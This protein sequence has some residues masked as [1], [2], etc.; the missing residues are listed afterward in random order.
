MSTK[1]IIQ[2][3]VSQVVDM[4]TGE[5][6]EASSTNI[7]RL[8]SEPPYV[9]MYLDDLCVLINVPESQKNLLLHLLRRL[10]FEGYIILSPRARKD[11]AKSLGI[12][13]QTFR[14]RL[15]ELCKSGIIHRASTNEYMANPS[16]FA[17]GEWK[18]ICARRQ[19]FEL[20]ITY[21]DKGRKIETGKIEVEQGEL[22]LN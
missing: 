2:S 11:I 12:A 9:K 20:K 15:N 18:S 7:Y 3:T 10:D 13:D 22:P 8:P 14:N 1:K 4:Q 16:Y 17:R 21:S 5:I 6:V 19:A